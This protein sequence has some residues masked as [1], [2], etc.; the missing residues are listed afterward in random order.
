MPDLSTILSAK[1]SL[2]L[3]GVPTGFQ[4]LLLA[5]LTRAAGRAVFIAPDDAAMRALAQT[6]PF[7]APELEVITF[8]AWDCLPYD[9]ASPSLRV[10]AERV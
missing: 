9:R 5:D 4:P 8:P 6:T 2:T 1:R 10:M 3:A 7:F